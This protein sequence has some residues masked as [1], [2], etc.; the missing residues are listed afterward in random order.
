MSADLWRAQWVGTHKETT[1]SPT[2]PYCE[3]TPCFDILP[4]GSIYFVCSGERGL[5]LIV[6]SWNQQRESDGY[7]VVYIV[8]SKQIHYSCFPFL[9][10]IKYKNLVHFLWIKQYCEIHF[11]NYILNSLLLSTIITLYAKLI[12]SNI[13]GKFIQFNIHSK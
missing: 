4:P 11:V 10:Y 12:Q 1:N 9:F 13:H 3:Q 7:S 8:S 6:F 2:P 5:F